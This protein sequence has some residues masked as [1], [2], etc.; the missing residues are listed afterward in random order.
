MLVQFVKNAF[1]FWDYG[2]AIV[3]WSYEARDTRSGRNNLEM[4][5]HE[6]D[7]CLDLHELELHEKE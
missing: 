6:Y 4:E 7:F 5:L 1:Y 2:N 3:S